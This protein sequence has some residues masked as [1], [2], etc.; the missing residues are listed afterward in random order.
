MN[1]KNKCLIGL[2]Y[3]KKRKT[4]KLGLHVTNLNILLFI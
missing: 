2:F 1:R 3:F 4:T